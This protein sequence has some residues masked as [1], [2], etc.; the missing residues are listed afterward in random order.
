GVAIGVDQAFTH[1][2][3][4]VAVVNVY[5]GGIARRAGGNGA[6]A[7]SITAGVDDWD[8]GKGGAGHV[9]AAG[10][11]HETQG[12]GVADS[13]CRHDVAVIVVA[14]NIGV[15]VDELVEADDAVI[16]RHEPVLHAG[17]VPRIAGKAGGRIRTEDVG[18]I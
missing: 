3:A 13:A 1:S 5:G 4:V 15:D 10:G 2:G 12:F 9:H 16:E 18:Q 6:D 11:I 14:A 17:I 7:V 8:T